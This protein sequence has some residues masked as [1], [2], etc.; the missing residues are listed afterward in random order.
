MENLP[1]NLKSLDSVVNFLGVAVL[2]NE[3]SD[4]CLINQTVSNFFRLSLPQNFQM[5]LFFLSR[6]LLVNAKGSLSLCAVTLVWEAY[7]DDCG[8][9]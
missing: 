1:S 5:N 6:C 9:Q 7:L 8:L 2:R 3:P 4:H